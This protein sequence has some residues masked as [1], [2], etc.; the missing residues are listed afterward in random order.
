M[1]RLTSLETS[2]TAPIVL[3]GVLAGPP[4]LWSGGVLSFC[5]SG[6]VQL[7]DPASG[8]PLASPLQVSVQPG[9]PLEHCSLAAAGKSAVLSD[10]QAIRLLSVEKSPQ[11]HLAEQAI[12]KLTSPTSSPVAALS[13]HVFVVDRG[14]ALHAFALPGLT[15]AQTWPLAASSIVAG[16]IRAGSRLLVATGQGELWCFDD[17]PKQLWKVP[18]THGPLAGDPVAAAGSLIVA[19]RTGILERLDENTGKATASLDLGQTLAGTPVVQGQ[20][21][22]VPAADGTLLKVNLPAEGGNP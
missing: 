16:P 20:F 13:R 22:L 4:I 14:G 19:S 17:E 8:S 18:L 5:S 10:G 3:P 2:A 21:V 15:P 1:L 9:R 12:A 7:L 6:D 11:P